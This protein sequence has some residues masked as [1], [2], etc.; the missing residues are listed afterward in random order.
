MLVFRNRNC[1]SLFLS[2]NTTL[3][4]LQTLLFLLFSKICISKLGVRLIEGCGLYT[5][6]YGVLT[7]LGNDWLITVHAPTTVSNI[8][9]ANSPTIFRFFKKINSE[10]ATIDLTLHCFWFA[11]PSPC[12]HRYRKILFFTPFA[13]L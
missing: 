5:D 8:F 1:L 3:L 12:L 2:S 7:K 13:V 11:F 4:E 9:F 6:V 10:S